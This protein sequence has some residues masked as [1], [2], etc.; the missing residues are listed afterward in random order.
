MQVVENLTKSFELPTIPFLGRPIPVKVQR[1]PLLADRVY[2]QDGILTLWIP[3]AVKAVELAGRARDLA[4][5]WLRGQAGRLFP[6]RVARMNAY[7]G[8]QIGAISIKDARSRWGS[9]S[10]RRNLN[11]NWRIIMAPLAVVD[12]LVVHE[13]SHLKEMNHSARFWQTVAS[14]CPDYR[15]HEV[16]LKTCG[17][18]LLRWGRADSGF[19]DTPPRALYNEPA[20]TSPIRNFGRP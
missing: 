3:Q 5:R 14:A 1:T 13:L 17:P 7:F 9:C 8:F 19:L 2:E 6:E 11:F 16:W 20:S 4:V 12:Y 10:V 18:N 15:S